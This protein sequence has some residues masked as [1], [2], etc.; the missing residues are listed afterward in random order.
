[1]WV[2]GSKHLDHLLLLLWTL[3]TEWEV[4][5][6]RLEPVPIW[7]A[8]ISGS[9]FTCYATV[10]SLTIFFLKQRFITIQYILK[11][12]V[13]GTEWETNREK[14]MDSIWEIFHFQMPII[15]RAEAGWS[16]GPRTLLESPPAMTGIQALRQL[17]QKHCHQD[18]NQHSDR[19]VVLQPA[20]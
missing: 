5:Q 13:A 15:I 11:G 16:Q 19:I 12:I 8:S 20:D 1:M 7:D 2:Q 18:W 10:A 9:D 3:A 6:L 4:E 17:D 14:E